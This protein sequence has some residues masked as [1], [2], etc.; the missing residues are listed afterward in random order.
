[1]GAVLEDFEPATFV[2][3]AIIGMMD[4]LALHGN[5]VIS[6]WQE[7]AAS[8]PE[9]LSRATVEHYLQFYPLWLAAEQWQSRDATIF[10]NQMLVEVSLNMLGVL[11]GLNRHYFSTFQFKRLH[12]FADALHFAPDRL[13][14]RIDES[15]SLDPVGAG[16]V[17]ERLVEE[18]V[19]LV[20]AHMLEVDTT[21]VRQNLGK[22]QRPWHVPSR[23]L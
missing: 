1:M 5:D 14:D 20:E 21:P 18:I 17:I 12:H 11:A 7:R 13:A 16:M 10:F 23:L 4:G 8:Y 3:K 22:R 19:L 2:E 6:R 15:F 9:E